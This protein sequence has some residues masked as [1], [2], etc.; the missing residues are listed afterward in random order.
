MIN[1]LCASPPTKKG[2]CVC[3][4][5][6][7]RIVDDDARRVTVNT[8]SNVPHDVYIW[9]MLLCAVSANAKRKQ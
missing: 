6:F 9:Y 1:I 5:Y 8:Y 7:Y 3:C 4:W 2:V